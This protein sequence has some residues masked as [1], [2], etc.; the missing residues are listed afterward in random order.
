MCNI[1]G[2]VGSERAAPILLDMLQAE[3]GLAGGYYT[4]LAT[5]HEGKLHHAKV[6]GDTARL[7]AQTDAE[8]LPGTI[9]IAH[10][11]SNSGGDSE[12]AH[13]FIGCG[14]RLAYIANGSLGYWAE[15][16]RLQAGAQRLADDGH[17]YRAVHDEPIGSYPVLRDGTCVH[18]SDVMAHAIGAA[19]DELGDPEAAIRKAFLD[20][21]SEIV[22]LYVSVRYP[23]RIYGARW[24]MPCCAARD[25]KGTYL[26][27]APMA[28]PRNFT[29]HTWI[30]PCSVFSAS[31]DTLTL[32][33]LSSPDEAL[34]DDINGARA[35]E[36][37]LE[38]LSDGKPRTFG[39]LS[40]AV[41]AL[42]GRQDRVVKC[43]AVYQVLHDLE[44]ED[45]LSHETARVPGAEDGLTAPQF[46]FFLTRQSG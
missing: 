12:W 4:G 1:A 34:S 45:L 6:V 13:P 35:R 24:N 8:E 39:A 17:R 10:S 18:M 21:P 33:P 41:A 2:Y 22:G 5:I 43:D 11:R 40:K 36:V 20:L 30:P 46:R 15:D 7:R 31:G 25:N 29:W 26:A 44:S 9:G 16:E 3:E 14:D 23:D 32:A 42:S 28:F 38:E 27:S 37:I 19:L